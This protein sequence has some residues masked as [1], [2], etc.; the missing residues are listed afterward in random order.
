MRVK[1]QQIFPNCQKYDK[2]CKD[3]K[4]FWENLGERTK[5]IKYR[6]QPFRTKPVKLEFTK[7]PKG[8]EGW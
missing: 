8:F 4:K 5:I 6:E 3:N 1:V 7:P 2:C